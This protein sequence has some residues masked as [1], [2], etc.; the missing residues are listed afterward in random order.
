MFNLRLYNRIAKSNIVFLKNYFFF[1]CCDKD[2]SCENIRFL[3]WYNK[4]KTVSKLSEE[5]IALL[6]KGLGQQFSGTSVM[7]SSK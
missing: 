3:F 6:Y 4:S 5:L 7:V 1:L 2:F